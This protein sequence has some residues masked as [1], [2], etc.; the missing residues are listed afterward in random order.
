MLEYNQKTEFDKLTLSYAPTGLVLD[1]GCGNGRF[2]SNSLT[3]IWGIDSSP[4]SINECLS[5]NYN[6]IQGTIPLLPFPA[7]SFR[8]VNCSHIIEHLTPAE[9]HKLLIE[10][11]RVLVPRGI[12]SI[13]APLLYNH[14][15]DDLTHIKPYTPQSII[16]YLVRKST[17]S[18]QQHTFSSVSN[19]YTIELL[20]YRYS[21][22]IEF[23]IG[24]PRIINK[25]FNYLLKF[26]IH[27]L[28]K[29]GYLLILRKGED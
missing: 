16:H 9:L 25:I 5:K 27:G 23:P 10:I 12:L 4:S 6:V 2:I 29:T 3:R 13:Q 7:C 19:N 20:K 11:N 1:V 15:Y 21:R 22:L 24:Y 14:F 28:K 17:A 26:N 18:D 8:L